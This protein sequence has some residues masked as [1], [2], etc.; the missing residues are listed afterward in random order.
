MRYLFY[1][2]WLVI[3]PAS[4]LLIGYVQQSLIN[5]YGWGVFYRYRDRDIYGSLLSR[6]ERRMFWSGVVLL[7]VFVVIIFSVIAYPC[8]EQAVTRSH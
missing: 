5:S 7:L 4:A 1:A 2:A 3:A 6:R 8:N